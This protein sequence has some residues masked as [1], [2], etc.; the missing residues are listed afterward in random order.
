MELRVYPTSWL[1]L[2]QIRRMA[3]KRRVGSSGTV[4]DGD[5]WIVCSLVG[6]FGSAS[7]LDALV[8]F[9]RG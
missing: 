7:G 4:S 2:A 5:P 8:P 1:P 6:S 3:Q 9:I